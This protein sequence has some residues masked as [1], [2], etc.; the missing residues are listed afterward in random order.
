MGITTS[1]PAGGHCKLAKGSRRSGQH[2]LPS[3][4][5]VRADI[6]RITLTA[7]AVF[8]L[9]LPAYFLIG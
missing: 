6:L 2:D 3:L 1:H 8:A 7:L 4:G 5:H 9:L